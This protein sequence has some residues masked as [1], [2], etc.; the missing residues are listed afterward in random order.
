MLSKRPD[1]LKLVRNTVFGYFL[2]LS[3]IGMGG[4]CSFLLRKGGVFSPLRFLNRESISCNQF[5][6]V[7]MQHVG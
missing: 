6:W 1:Y 2:H 3:W 4:F 5:L 7:R